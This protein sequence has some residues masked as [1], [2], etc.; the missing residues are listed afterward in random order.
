MKIEEHSMFK[1]LFY[2][3]TEVLKETRVRE[4]SDVL[5]SYQSEPK[6]FPHSRPWPRLAQRTAFLAPTLGPEWRHI[7]KTLTHLVADSRSVFFNSSVCVSRTFKCLM[8]K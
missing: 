2:R 4:R 1:H 3:K 5:H 8:N 6:L 7:L